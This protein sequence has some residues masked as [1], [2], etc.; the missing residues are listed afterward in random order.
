[1]QNERTGSNQ[2]VVCVKH[3]KHGMPETDWNETMP[4]PGD[5]IEGVTE[6]DPDNPSSSFFCPKHKSDLNSQLG[7][8]NRHV[9][10]VWVKVRRGNTTVN[11]HVNVVPEST[12]KLKRRFTIRAAGDQRHVVVLGDM[13]VDECME[14]QEMSMRVVSVAGYKKRWASYDWKKKVGTYMPHQRSS[15][16][17]SILFFPFAEENFAV[18]AT[19]ARSMAWL[20]AAV[21]SGVP[22]I[23]V[24]IQ[25]EQIITSDKSTPS[26]GGGQ[27]SKREMCW[28]RQQNPNSTIHIVQGIRLWFLPGVTEVLVNLTPLPGETRFG[29]EIKRTEE[30]FICIYSVAN[31]Y[32][33]DRAGLHQMCEQAISSGNIMVIA[34][35]EGKSLLPSSVLS[36]GLIH[37]CDHNDVRDTLATAIDRM[38]GI[39]LYIMAWPSLKASH[40]PPWQA[41]GLPTLKPPENLCPSE[42]PSGRTTSQSAG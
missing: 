28:S 32:A 3:V 11:L 9:D 4:L 13:T 14:L 19:T 23:F 29:M 33:A 22:L 10:E 40:H 15:V 21:S 2:T 1:M 7:R 5:I 18:E 41:A 24:N 25:T 42:V 35:L 6:S 31:G 37:C 39:E 36:T 8:L 27:T 16:L 17:S 34:R 20:S 26:G 38:E 12:A 30:G